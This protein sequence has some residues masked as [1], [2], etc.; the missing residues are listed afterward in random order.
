MAPIQGSCQCRGIRFEI[1]GPLT[2]A[3]N[4][5]CSMCRKLQGS[6]F[7]SRAGVRA[8]DFHFISGEDLVTF[9]ESSPGTRRGFCRVCGSPIASWF[10]F[11]PLHLG[12]PLGGLDDDPGVRPAMHVFV[13]DKAPWFTI[14]DD[15]PQFP[16]RP[17]GDR[18]G[19]NK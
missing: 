11:D 7:R 17:P 13:A 3:L 19:L 4:C 12:L 14:T 18:T 15:L 6:A 1:R 16:E 9:Y 5:H 10:D 2:G 8:S